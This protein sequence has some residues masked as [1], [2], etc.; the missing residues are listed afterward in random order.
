MELDEDMIYNNIEELKNKTILQQ[1]ISMQFLLLLN[2]CET[3]RKL[4]R[5]HIP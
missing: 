5:V 1:N 4:L 3:I 2:K